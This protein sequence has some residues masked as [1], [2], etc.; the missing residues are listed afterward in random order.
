MY[1]FIY[2][3]I[4]LHTNETIPYAWLY[5][6]FIDMNLPFYLN[7]KSTSG[8][9]FIIDTVLYKKSEDLDVLKIKMVSSYYTV[10]K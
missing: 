3:T 9:S 5:K 6:K 10:E 2:S 7:E 1:H 4:F 8:K